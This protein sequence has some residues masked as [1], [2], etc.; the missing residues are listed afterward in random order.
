MVENVFIIGIDGAGRSVLNAECPN[1]T[2]FRK[3]AVLAANTY[4]VVPSISAECWGSMFT[5][6]L[7]EQH[8][9]TNDNIAVVPHTLDDQY[10]SLFRVIKEKLPQWKIASF[11]SWKPINVGIVED[12]PGVVKCSE[13]DD[14]VAD[15]AAEYIRTTD[16][17]MA[18]YIHLDDL[19]HI[20]HQLDYFTPEY[21]K[22]WPKVD[23]NVGKL[24]DA[25]KQ[26]G[27]LDNSLILITTD[28]GGGAIPKS[29]GTAEPQDVETF[30]MAAGGTLGVNTSITHKVSILDVAPVILKQLGISKPEHMLGNPDALDAE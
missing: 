18:F 30:I 1:I 25:I 12:L 24:L 15:A 4:T 29:H 27:K 21:M 20:G 10:P 22:V 9:Y 16:G 13:K 3:S 14:E 23:R 6:V 28:H 5:S 2:E 7:P 11:S 26:S 17:P 19:D 8:G